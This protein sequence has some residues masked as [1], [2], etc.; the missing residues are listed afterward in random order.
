MHDSINVRIYVSATFPSSF[1]TTFVLS[2]LLCEW[3]PPKLQTT[4]F[5]LGPI[6]FR[7]QPTEL[8]K[9]KVNKK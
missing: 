3:F 2:L 1:S 5:H 6:K 4:A 8:Q 9:P 7:G